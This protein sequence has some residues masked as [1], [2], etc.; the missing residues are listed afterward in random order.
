MATPMNGAIVYQGIVASQIAAAPVGVK[1]VDI[2]D[3]NGDLFSTSQVAKMESGG[4]EL[5][6]YFDIGHAE[7]WRP[8]WSTLPKS[9]LG[10][11]MA[12]SPG[13][14]QVA[15]W[16]SDWLKVA[17]SYIQTMIDRGY[18]GAFFDNMG[19]AETPWAE[20]H[21]PQEKAIGA[22]VDLIQEL[23]SYARAKD[24]SFKIWVNASGDEN[25]LANSALDKTINGDVEES[26]FYQ[27]PMSPESP[28]YVAANLKFLDDL[29]KAGKSVLDVEYISDASEV[30]SVE[31]R[32]RADGMGYYIAGPD[33]SLDGVD[34]QGFRSVTPSTVTIAHKTLSVAENGGQVNLDVR[35]TAPASSAATTVTIPSYETITDKL[36]GKTFSGSS[37]ALSAAEVDS[38]LILTSHYRG[39][40]HPS[41][42]LT[43]TAR[44]TIEGFIANSMPQTITVK[45]PPAPADAPFLIDP[46]LG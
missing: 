42:K 27:A 40:K 44:D 18:D 28:S 24:P 45:D 16:A 35:V 33:Q 21:A 43:I 23:A 38:G 3:D 26:L 1:I 41:A 13:E 11:G 46:L 12:G 22:M 39:G 8:Y 32:A 30:A 5:L 7:N 9:I 6:G 19:E 36:D 2:Y 14:Y 15:Y 17:E 4:G 29:I 25:M 31:A 10:P 20:A 34:T 37:I